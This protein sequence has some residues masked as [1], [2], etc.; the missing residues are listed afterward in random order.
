[1][2][3]VSVC[4]GDTGYVCMVAHTWAHEEGTIMGSPVQFSQGIIWGLG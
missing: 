4:A 2:C 3:V 1:M